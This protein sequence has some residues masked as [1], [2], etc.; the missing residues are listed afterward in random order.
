[1][2]RRDCER[3]PEHQYED[4]N[5][6]GNERAEGDRHSPDDQGMCGQTGQDRASSAKTCYQIA[7]SENCDSS[8]SFDARIA[9]TGLD[10]RVC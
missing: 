8:C 7:K 4:H 1:M 5:A 9:L 3:K 2:S 10:Q 6:R